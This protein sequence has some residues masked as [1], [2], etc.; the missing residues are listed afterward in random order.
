MNVGRLKD[1][2]IIQQFSRESLLY[3]VD[4]CAV[5][6]VFDYFEAGVFKTGKK[7]VAILAAIMF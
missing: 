1:G 3:F 7:S 2:A 4:S 5:R 6:A